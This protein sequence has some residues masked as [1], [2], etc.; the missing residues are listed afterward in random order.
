M[1]TIPVQDN[2]LLEGLD[3]RRAPDSCILVIF[4]ASGD[5][6][7]RKLFPA[8]YSLAFRNLLPEHFAVVG[9][10]RSEE[11]DD[12]FRDRMKAAV[13]EHSR[14]PF[15]DDVWEPLAE[16]MHY[17]A[18]DFADEERE[19]SLAATLTKLD[20][21]RQTGGNRV[22]YLATP[23]AVFQTVVKAVGTRRSA[24]GWARLIIEKPFGHDLVSAKELQK[25]IETYF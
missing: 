17:V 5:L 7:K 11:S 9:V 3:I 20:E 21:E 23:P 1:T 25:V 2:P 22:Y 4:G 19:D 10:S 13:Q 16:G 15:R 14:D 8:L 18:M 6:T 12:E 24:Q